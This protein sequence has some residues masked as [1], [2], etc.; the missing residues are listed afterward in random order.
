MSDG[1][2]NFYTEHRL[3]GLTGV[4]ARNLPELL[5]GLET[6]PGASIFYHTH[7]A[8]LAHHFERLLFYND[9]A[10]WVSEALHQ[11]ALAERLV[12]IDLLSFTTIRGLREAIIALVAEHMSRGE[13][14]PGD[15]PPGDEFHFC[16]SKSFPV[17]T[18]I[19]A[20][21]IPEFFEKLNQ[22]TTVSL[23]Y[24]FFEARL[25]LGRAT[26]DFSRWIADQGEPELARAIDQLDPYIRTLEELRGDIVNL[27][28]DRVRCH[29]GGAPGL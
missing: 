4:T 28:R 7:Q 5:K 8:Y 29:D 19:V 20:R 27:G 21:D 17:P 1:P 16:R 24:H 18:N 11:D 2:F 10:L 26:N 13:W 25:R 14:L 15:C 9:F 12:A 3:I 23:F 22:V 6:V